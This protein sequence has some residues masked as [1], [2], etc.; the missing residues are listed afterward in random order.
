[1]FLR[2]WI[3]GSPDNAARKIA[4]LAEE[5]GVSEMMINPVTA[6]YALQPANGAPNRELT[7]RAL[8][9]RLR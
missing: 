1:M 2:S 9:E 8:A 7:L 6:A 4:S 5:L 3:I